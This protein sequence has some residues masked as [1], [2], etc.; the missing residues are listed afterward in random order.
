[1]YKK[2]DSNIIERIKKIVGYKNVITNKEKMEDYTHDEYSLYLI[3]NYPEVVIKPRN[4]K[5]ISEILKLANLENFPVTPRGGGTGLCG[6]C[7]PIKGGVVLSLENMNKILEIDK[8]NLVIVLEPGVRLMDLYE[9]VEESDL[10]FPLHPGDESAN[11]GGII[12][13]NAGGARAIK[14]G[15]TRNFVRGLE[16]VLPDGDIINVGGKVMKDCTGYNL[17]NLFIGSEGTLGIITKAIIRLLPKL[18]MIT[19]LVIPY[20]NLYD[21][22]KTVPEIIRNLIIP[23]G[24]EFIEK[25][26]IPPTESYLGKKWPTKLGNAY[27]MII[28][29]SSTEEELD[30]LCEKVAD[31]CTSNKAIDVLIADSKERQKD[32]LDIRSNIYEALKNETIE[33]LDITVPPSKIADYVKEVHKVSK[34]Y[35]IWLPC[36]GHAGDGNVHTNIMKSYKWEEK[37]PIIRERL[38]KIGIELGGVISG[39]H[40]IGFVKKEYLSMIGEKKIELFRRIKRA[41]DPN[42]ILNPGKII[43]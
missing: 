5:E 39:E 11:V 17:M 36:Y 10:F 6:G 4:S 22:I 43:D 38:H 42:N 25:E 33:I 8:D 35:N 41:F 7:V 3:K 15:V 19:T 32:I 1:M 26:V 40:G 20:D 30:S 23:L 29:D 9:K 37:Y 28:I 12:A 14:Y 13:T 34:K 16:V 18:K 27:L 24:I 2:I 21:A 31:I